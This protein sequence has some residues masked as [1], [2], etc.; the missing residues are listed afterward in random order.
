[1]AEHYVVD[2]GVFVRWHI[3]QQPGYQQAVGLEKRFL[4]GDATLETVDFVRYELGNVLRKKALMPGLITP[5]QFLG[6]VRSIDD[7][8]IPVHVTSADV[9]ERVADLSHRHVLPFF[10]AI[11]VVWSLELGLPL[12]TTDERLCRGAAGITRVEPLSGL[13]S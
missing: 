1:M 8:G 7:L 10:D 5:V 4:D 6:A 11:L 9:L 12:L 2:T 3:P 13:P